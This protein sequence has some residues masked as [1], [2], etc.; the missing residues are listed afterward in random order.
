MNL[1]KFIKTLFSNHLIRKTY[2][3]EI[4]HIG[5]MN[6]MQINNLFANDGIELR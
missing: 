4:K 6:Q 1:F 3:A 2:N 5:E